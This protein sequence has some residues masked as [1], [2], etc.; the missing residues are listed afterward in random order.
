MENDQ[1]VGL[2]K[3][4]EGQREAIRQ[5]A[6]NTH[7]ESQSTR[8]WT[9]GDG[10][11]D[12]HRPESWPAFEIDILPKSFDLSRPFN[13]DGVQG[14]PTCVYL[15]SF[16]LNFLLQQGIP[17]AVLAD[18]YPGNIDANGSIN[19]PLEQRNLNPDKGRTESSLNSISW[20]KKR[21]DGTAVRYS[22]EDEEPADPLAEQKNKTMDQTHPARTRAQK[23]RETLQTSGPS[24][25]QPPSKQQAPHGNDLGSGVTAMALNPEG[26]VIEITEH[27]GTT[28]NLGQSL[29]I[30]ATRTLPSPSTV[31]D[32]SDIG[33][34]PSTVSDESDI[35]TH[36]PREPQAEDAD[37]IEN[38]EATDLTPAS[39]SALIRITQ[40]V[41]AVLQSQRNNLRHR[42]PFQGET[43]ERPPTPASYTSAPNVNVVINNAS[44]PPPPGQNGSVP[45]G[46]SVEGSFSFTGLKAC[47]TC[48]EFVTYFCKW[49]GGIALGLLTI[50]KTP[51]T[52]LCFISLALLGACRM[53]WFSSTCTLC[54]SSP[55]N[56]TCQVPVL[57][58]LLL[59]CEEEGWN[60]QEA[61]NVP[62][63][64]TSIADD[65][66][67]ALALP[68]A[69]ESLHT[70]LTYFA[71]LIYHSDFSSKQ[72]LGRAID[73][74]LSN[75]RDGS[76]ELQDFAHDVF[77]LVD[78]IKYETRDAS[79]QLTRLSNSWVY[80]SR[81]RTHILTPLWDSCRA[82]FGYSKHD[83]L[84]PH[85]LIWIELFDVLAEK[86]TVVRNRGKKIN[87]DFRELG[88]KLK[89]IHH[90]TRKEV[91]SLEDHRKQKKRRWF[92]S[93]L[94]IE[95]C[96]E[97]IN[98][99]GDLDRV[100]EAAYDIIGQVI[101]RLDDINR[102]IVL[103]RDKLSNPRLKTS[104]S[105]SRQIEEITNAV[106]NLE[107]TKVSMSAKR[108]EIISREATNAAAIIKGL[109]AETK[110]R[111]DQARG[112]STP[113][114]KTSHEDGWISL[115]SSCWF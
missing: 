102:N 30:D 83:P 61:F 53:D 28:R 78:E 86:L 96:N 34:S 90:L 7:R 8:R 42:L 76:N 71:P 39:E 77:V 36:S 63:S 92:Q 1:V 26:P 108:R 9:L 105:L 69:F 33:P 74:F 99:L 110:K 100:R 112:G 66:P 84:E 29:H 98:V 81:V 52:V 15:G 80:S 60:M 106:N 107:D 2:I 55:N 87:V 4:P 51:L 104:I 23:M 31:S 93:E 54:A 25:S 10:H 46:S 18:A 82:A 88:G 24:R 17:L 91:K 113:R 43:I 45:S 20:V 72:E 89:E 79:D 37:L 67:N 35:G 5:R 64:F 40:A 21:D 47:Q 6:L 57:W 49:V 58:R 12:P 19:Q 65:G 85:R 56:P 73:I 44:S 94:L 115:L 70:Q 41:G 59:F 16:A 95:D 114:A 50:F 111:S 109:T 75:A 101:Y 22:F 13:E 48:S 97:Q 27:N 11:G 3:V 68:Y 14:F 32:E 62:N 103:T 38:Q